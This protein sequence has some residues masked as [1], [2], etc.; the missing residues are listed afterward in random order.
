MKRTGK[1][2]GIRLSSR[3]PRK[4]SATALRRPGPSVEVAG[5]AC[6]GSIAAF[7]VVEDGEVAG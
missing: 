5:F 1:T 7:G 4:A 3:P 6:A 2:Q